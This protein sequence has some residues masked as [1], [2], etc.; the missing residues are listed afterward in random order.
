MSQKTN[1][2]I[3]KEMVRDIDELFDN[4]QSVYRV[5]RTN[6]K[7]WKTYICA[8]KGVKSKTARKI[9]REFLKLLR[10]ISLGQFPPDGIDRDV[11]AKLVAKYSADIETLDATPF[12]QEVAAE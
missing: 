12:L 6:N 5:L 2:G 3:T 9:V 10:D 11:G 4:D 1:S 8:G 7:T